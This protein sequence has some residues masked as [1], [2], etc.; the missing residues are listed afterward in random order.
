VKQAKGQR[1]QAKGQRREA[2][3]QTPKGVVVLKLGGELLEQR[4]D[5]DRIAEGI[6]RLAARGPLAVVHGGGKEI[7]AG[8]AAAGIQKVQVD[9]I[10]VTDAAT[11]DVVVAV[12][13]GAINTRLVAA[14]RA[15]GARPVGLTGADAGV[16]SIRKAAPLTRSTGEKVSLG[17][18]GAPR[19]NGAPA[20][21]TDLVSRGY[22]PVIACIGATNDG[23]I[24][25]VNADTLAAHLAVGLRAGRLVIAGG[26][27]GVL[28]DDGRTIE[29]VDDRQASR[30]IKQGTASAGMV[31]KLQACRAAVRG[32]VGDVVIVNGRE[33]DFPALRGAVKQR[34]PFAFT[35]VVAEKAGSNA[36]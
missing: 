13:A 36:R 11:L 23:Q 12:L 27:A 2:K 32:G 15:A 26:T 6:A 17:L 7:D 21:V 34:A 25:N 31:A 9:G 24:L 33:A 18:V 22:V 28:D 30:L 8:L 3:G 19:G 16:V 14:L 4:A 5:V 10:R 20:L 35:Q 1:R 29:R